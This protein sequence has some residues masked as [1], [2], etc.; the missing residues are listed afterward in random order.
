MD[1]RGYDATQGVA[2]STAR[3]AAREGHEGRIPHRLFH[4]CG[5]R[6]FS[7]DARAAQVSVRPAE[8]AARA[9]GRRQDSRRHGVRAADRPARV[10]QRLVD[11]SARQR[12]ARYPG[13]RDCA[14]RGDE[15]RVQ[16]IHRRRRL[17]RRAVLAGPQVHVPRSGTDLGASTQA[18]RRCDRPRRTLRLATQHLPWRARRS[19]G[20]WHQLVRSRCVCAFPQGAVTDYPSLDARGIHAVRPDV[21][22]CSGDQQRE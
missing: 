17:R 21:S 22:D 3:R 16:G 19:A 4:R 12:S 7:R 2:R 10:P 18:L 14:H 11:E 6:A 13:I 8:R 15:S 9:R 5:A 20:R 1:P